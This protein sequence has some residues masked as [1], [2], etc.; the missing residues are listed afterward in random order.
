MNNLYEIITTSDGSRTLRDKYYDVPFH[1]VHGAVTESIHVFIEAG[2]A[3]LANLPGINILEIGFGTGLNA[4]LTLLYGDAHELKIRYS[5]VDPNALPLDLVHSLGY[6]EY[7]HKP[8]AH[9]LLDKLHQATTRTDATPRFSI[10]V[11][12]DTVQSLTPE[13]TFNLVYYDAFAPG[14]QPEMWTLE[15]LGYVSRMLLPGAVLVTY[16]AKG[17]FKR[18]LRSLGFSVESLPGPPGKREMV[19]AGWHPR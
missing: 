4:L 9:E 1:S 7:L 2:L 13:P 17:Q 8:E 11:L 18:D 5:G 6:A 15:T 10:Q 14:A 3:P 16:C 19:R 12:R